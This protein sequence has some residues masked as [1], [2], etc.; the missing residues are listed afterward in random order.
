MAE[1]RRRPADCPRC[2]FPAGPGLRYCGRCG[3]DFD[4]PEAITAAAPPP[5][6]LTALPDIE[7][8]EP[9]PAAVKAAKEPKPPKGEAKAGQGA[10]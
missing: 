10:W 3:L 7:R 8:P 9:A 1:P 5:P 6:I 2:D 4:G